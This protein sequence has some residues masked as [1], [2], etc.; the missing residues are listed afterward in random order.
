MNHQKAIDIL[1]GRRRGLV[2]SLLRA[3]LAAASRPY[4][5]A[6][7]LRRW[8]YRA[9]LLPS[10]AASVPVICVGNITTGGT[11]KTPM[12]IWA[13]RQLKALGKNP[14]ILTRGYKATGGASDEAEL[15][16]GLTGVEVVV[17]RDR[18]AGARQA[19]AGGADV[20]VM[21]DGFQHRR[22]RRDLDIV[23]IDASNPFGYGRCL[24]RGLLR[25]PRSALR[26]AHA[27]VV[28][29]GDAI[30]PRQ[31]DALRGRLGRL[32]PQASLH[33]AVHRPVAVVDENGSEHPLAELAGRKACAFC[34][35][36]NPEQF[37]RQLAELGARL[38]HTRSFDDHVAYTPQLIDSLRRATSNCDSQIL[39]TTQK[40]AVKLTGAD[41]G[42]PLWTLAVEIEVTEGE[43]PLLDRIQAALAAGH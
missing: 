36:A 17:N 22:L 12:A 23:L 26:D 15:L 35:I 43:L 3:A 10:K 38:V 37:F 5:A 39:L 1:S 7:G 21:D 33:T 34:G 16:K 2:A 4:A 32:A 28:T 25:E 29:R 14:A 13:V 41:L 8:A 11:G 19:V 40:D 6:M 9:G 20:V 30:S 24:P 18:L 42:R 31:L 27:I